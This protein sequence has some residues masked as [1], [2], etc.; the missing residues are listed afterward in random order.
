M[1]QSECGGVKAQAMLRQC[2]VSLPRKAMFGETC[3][4]QAEFIGMTVLA[5]Q[6]GSSRDG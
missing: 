4:G 3:I 6:L 5:A 1:A 2:G